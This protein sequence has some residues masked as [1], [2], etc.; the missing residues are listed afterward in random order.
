[1]EWLKQTFWKWMVHG[2][3]FLSIIWLVGG[4]YAAITTITDVS[5]WDTLTAA[6]FNTLIANQEDLQT[7]INGI[8]AWPQ[9]PQWAT[10]AT[11]PQ[12]PAWSDGIDWESIPAGGVMAF[13]LSDCPTGW[14]KANGTANA[15]DLRW[16]F[17]RGL[18][19]SRW[20]D[21]GRVLASSQGDSFA[22][23]NHDL[24]WYGSTWASSKSRYQFWSLGQSNDANHYSSTEWGTETRP[25]NVALLYCVK[26]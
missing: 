25:R 15:L 26:D 9:W 21:S 16:E 5:S 24:K 3:G 2:L 23:H 1:M 4:A 11:G 7:Q 6:T 10:G 17:I 20:V 12:W 13:N 8:P 22:A 14:S 19:D 18:D